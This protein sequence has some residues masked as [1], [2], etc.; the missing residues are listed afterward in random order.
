[1]QLQ[2]EAGAVPEIFVSFLWQRLNAYEQKRGCEWIMQ[3]HAHTHTTTRSWDEAAAAALSRQRQQVRELQTLQTHTVTQPAA[4]R[5]QQVHVNQ[6]M[7]TRA[8]CCTNEDS[9]LIPTVTG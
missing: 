5:C 6:E 9:S 1:M 3:T 8:H 7:S 2:P 4:G